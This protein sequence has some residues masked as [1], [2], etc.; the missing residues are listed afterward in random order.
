M[1]F[2]IA[3][4]SEQVDAI[5]RLA[6]QCY[7]KDLGWEPEPGNPSEFRIVE[8][9][10]G[11]L[12]DD[13]LSYKATYFSYQHQGQLVAAGRF[14]LGTFSDVEIS[15]YQPRLVEKF[16]S[17]RLAEVNRICV[18]RRY[19][20]SPF[21][22]RMFQGLLRYLGEKK[23]CDRVLTTVAFPN[24]GALFLKLGF[25]KDSGPFRYG[26]NDLASV[27]LVS[28]DLTHTDQ[29]RKAQNLIDNLFGVEHLND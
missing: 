28:L 3:T 17:Q 14:L 20:E 23:L 25:T 8:A 15:R 26:T 24:P 2:Q 9:V 12:L 4:E 22:P 16:S 11:L 21:L 19:L 27:H 7:V 29:L 5:K 6:Y 13:A 10:D 18:D 1:G